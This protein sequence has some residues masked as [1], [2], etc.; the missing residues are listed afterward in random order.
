[1][2]ITRPY[3]SIECGVSECD[4]M[5]QYN[6]QVEEVRLRKKE[7]FVLCEEMFKHCTSIYG[8]CGGVSK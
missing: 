3:E 1:M 6:E 2:A 5:Q 8:V 7:I 4:Q